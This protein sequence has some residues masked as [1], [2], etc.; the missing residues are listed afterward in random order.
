MPKKPILSKAPLTDAVFAPLPLKAVRP[1]GELL[2]RLKDA[3]RWVGQMAWED[4]RLPGYASLAL[5][6]FDPALTEM[7]KGRV[8]AILAAQPEEGSLENGADLAAQASLIRGLIAWYAATAD[9]R[10]LVYLLKRL[11]Y[12]LRNADKLFADLNS[13][14]LTGE[15]CY[16]AICLY[17]WT[18]KSFLLNLM[19]K[20]R[21][22]GLDWTGFF[23][24]FP[25]TRPF[26]K[27]I[28]P[29]EMKRGLSS[30]DVQTRSYYEKQQIMADGLALARGLKTPAILSRFSGSSKEKEAGKI[31]LEKVMRYHGTAH[32]LFA[33]EPSLMGGDPSC[34]MDGRAVAEAMFSLEQ[35]LISQGGAWF[36]DAWEK[37]ALNI[38]TA[39]EKN[40]R[41]RPNQR[42]NGPFPKENPTAEEIGPWMD[43]WL[44]GMTGYASGLWM[45]AKDDGLALMGY[46]PSILRW[47]IGGT[48][49]SIRVEGKYPLDG[50]VKLSVQTK[51]PVAF[52]LHIRIPAWAENA[53]VQMNDEGAQSAEPGSFLVLNR[54]WQDGDKVHISLPMQPRLTRWHHQSTA[55]EYGPLLMALSVD[56]EQPLWQLALDPQ[57]AMTASLAGKPGEE[58]LKVSAVFKMIPGWTAKGD[59]L[60]MPPIQPETQGEA[61]KL[62]L[63]PYGETVC[64]MAQFP[65]APEA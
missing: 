11:Q 61:L 49:I 47:K 54:T 10:V 29:E 31:G 24:T 44:K 7:V 42:V 52:P 25:V 15:Y 13:A 9:K 4:E 19:E 20:L 14:A 63:T 32:G 37:I 34:G 48:A 45:A 39:M 43:A 57:E 35:L 12:V 8:D 64:R 41:V 62:N 53:C 23:H 33:A 58:K 18:G 1:Q 36:A 26:Q 21:A 30:P 55:V 28:P 59:R 38:L 2:K 27:H 5:L 16:A 65:V 6:T 3:A 60:Q 51:K 22:L 50:E 46:V 17:N 56:G 40:G